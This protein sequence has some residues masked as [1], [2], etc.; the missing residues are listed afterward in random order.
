[1]RSEPQVR[2]DPGFSKLVGSVRTQSSFGRYLTLRFSSTGFVDEIIAFTS[3]SIYPVQLQGF[4][5]GL[6]T[7]LYFKG[8]KMETALPKAWVSEE[9]SRQH[10]DLVVFR[11]GR[12]AEAFVWSP[13]SRPLGCPLPRI[14]SYCACRNA[15][16]RCDNDKGA[17]ATDGVTKKYIYRCS[18]CKA[19][20]IF[21]VTWSHRLQLVEAYGTKYLRCDWPTPPP[22]TQVL[23]EGAQPADPIDVFECCD[24]NAIESG[25]DIDSSE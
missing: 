11:P 5:N 2:R 19:R 20:L 15:R 22:H 9:R 14:E 21:L 23:F 24:Q 17:F 12:V 10:S 13:Q 7:L 8:E 16:W 1:M 6:L 4:I 25:S 3:S 18:R